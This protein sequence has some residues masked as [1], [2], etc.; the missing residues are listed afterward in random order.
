MQDPHLTDEW[1]SLSLA[2]MG[3]MRHFR[4]PEKERNSLASIGIE[5]E[6]RW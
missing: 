1:E 2:A 6:S 5:G 4:D 3:N